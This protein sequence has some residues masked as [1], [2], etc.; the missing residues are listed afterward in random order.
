VRHAHARADQTQNFGERLGSIYAVIDNQN[1][2]G[3]PILGL[4]RCCH[5][6]FDKRQDTVNSLPRGGSLTA[7]LHMSPPC[8][9][10]S[11]RT[12]VGPTGASSGAHRQAL[13]R[14]FRRS[15]P[16]YRST[17][18]VGLEARV[19]VAIHEARQVGAPVAT[20]NPL[21]DCVSFRTP[22]SITPAGCVSGISVSISLVGTPLAVSGRVP[23]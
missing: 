11:V 10:W 5:N 4:H 15:S 6:P 21:A 16:S 23:P 13:T 22:F 8:S 17:T 1:S 7:C 20:M 12:S 3:K 14:S 19:A 2:S 9:S 18:R